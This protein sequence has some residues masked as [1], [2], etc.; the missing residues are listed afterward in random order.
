MLLSHDLFPATTRS[1]MPPRDVKTFVQAI[2]KNHLVISDIFYET[3]GN[4]EDV[5]KKLK[6]RIDFKQF[7]KSLL[8]SKMRNALSKSA[9]KNVF[10][11]FSDNG[12]VNGKILSDDFVMK[13]RLVNSLVLPNEMPN[14]KAW[15][16]VNGWYTKESSIGVRDVID[17]L[18]PIE[19]EILD[20][21]PSLAVIF[22][23]G[24]L[25]EL[26]DPLVD[27][28]Y[29]WLGRRK[30]SKY[31]FFPNSQSPNRNQI[32]EDLKEQILIKR[33]E[34]FIKTNFASHKSKVVTWDDVSIDTEDDEDEYEGLKDSKSPPLMISDGVFSDVLEEVNAKEIFEKAAKIEVDKA[35]HQRGQ[36]SS[37]FLHGEA[38]TRCHQI[39]NKQGPGSGQGLLDRLDILAKRRELKRYMRNNNVVRHRHKDHDRSLSEAPVTTEVENAWRSSLRDNWFKSRQQM[40][41]FSPRC[42]IHY[43]KHSDIEKAKVRNNSKVGERFNVYT[44]KSKREEIRKKLRSEKFTKKMFK[45]NRSD[46]QQEMYSGSSMKSMLFHPTESGGV[47]HPLQSLSTMEY[48]PPRR[49]VTYHDLNDLDRVAALKLANTFREYK[50]SGDLKPYYPFN[51]SHFP[52]NPAVDKPSWR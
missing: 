52:R 11:Y 18:K 8:R 13:L 38:I 12:L 10:E 9:M 25:P 27:A 45:D 16:V 17:V 1:N 28:L 44:Q 42:V 40:L 36:L 20:I 41:A 50:N 43:S 22:K 39:V 6:N 5:D 29:S 31:T 49:T 37:S 51:Y 7:K 14:E 48:G 33:V 26:N 30:K 21:D 46:L 47:F 19:S 24:I 34:K 15:D 32:E 3:K 23:A 35:N 4:N 2:R